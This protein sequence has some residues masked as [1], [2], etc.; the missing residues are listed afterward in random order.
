M[1]KFFVF[2]TFLLTFTACTQFSSEYKRTKEE[3]DSL[4]LQIIKNEAEIN[5]IL[6]I[7]N[8]VEE[9]IQSI[10]ITDELLS[11]QKDSGLS[12]S[13][14]E[15]LRNHI[16]LINETLKNNRLKLNELQE[17]LNA[18][19]LR[20]SALQK[21]I[22]RL[23]KDM[24]EK[25]ELIVVLQKEVDKKNVQIEQLSQQIEELHADVKE[26]E[27]INISQ[28]DKINEQDT[29]LNTVYYCFGTKKE[30][31]EQGILTGGGI[32]SK[33]KALKGDFNYEYFLVAD[34]RKLTAIPLFS[35]KAAIKTNHPNGSY[36]FTKD[37]DGSLTLQIIHSSVFW[38][39]SPFLVIEIK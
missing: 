5:D 23:T 10:R 18:S 9:D 26:L 13:R 3:N 19:N 29:E 21:T 39:L 27:D 7:L 31:K 32:F 30:L 16:G 1:R 37:S 34:K 38:S 8:A 25:S 17:K 15:Q 11:I 28:V 24:N 2:Y 36:Q 14:R 22:D 35:S 33:S 6:S 4:K 20:F 12:N